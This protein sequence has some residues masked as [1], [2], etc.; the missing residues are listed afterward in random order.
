[1]SAVAFFY[2]GE[3]DARCPREKTC[4]PDAGAFTAL[5]T[6]FGNTRGNAFV[7]AFEPD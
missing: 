3:A 2:S 6:G 1:M 4:K 7:E 5:I